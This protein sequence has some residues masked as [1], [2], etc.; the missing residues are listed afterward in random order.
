MSFILPKTLVPL[1][2][3]FQFIH[4]KCKA[5]INGNQ[6]IAIVNRNKR[7]YCPN[8][9]KKNKLPLSERI[10]SCNCGYH[11]HRD[12]KS[13]ICI[14]REGLSKLVP[15]ERREF[16]L[17]EISTST[18]LGALSKIKGIQVSKLESLS[19]EVPT[20]SEQFTRLQS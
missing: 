2:N 19:Q 15:T 1:P 18:F 11:E 5:I 20:K 17:G 7:I 12:L 13:A 9:G 14:E 6:L 8:C 10:Y 16:T 4:T 3:T